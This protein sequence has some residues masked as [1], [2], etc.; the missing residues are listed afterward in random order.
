MITEQILVDIVRVIHPNNVTM[1]AFGGS[2]AA[3]RSD[4]TVDH[5]VLRRDVYRDL[6][7][8]YSISIL[9]SAVTWLELGAYIG[10]SGY[11]ILAPKMV[12]YLSEK[13]VALAE[14]GLLDEAER[15]LVYQEDPY[16]AFVARQFRAE[17][18]E[19]FTSLR[20]RV[21]TPIGITALDG[22]VDGIEAFRGEIIRKI[23]RAR[24]FVCILTRRCELVE[25]KFASSVWLYQEIG[26]AVALGKK[27]LLLV[28]RDMH[29]HYAGEL[30]KNYE[31]AIFDRGDYGPAF[32]EVARRISAD[33]A[34]YHIPPGRT[35]N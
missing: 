25:G 6:M 32:Q 1:G 18:D 8:R 3:P 24:Y 20:D 22:N 21:L 16:A 15:R 30:Q 9:E 4:R 35:V 33:L 14:S 17:D 13:G 28:E 26:A 10:Y 11:G 12:I 19:L 23:Q 2:D 27:P 31:Y 7:S 5:A 29:E 34:A